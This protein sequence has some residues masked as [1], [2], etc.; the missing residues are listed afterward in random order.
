MTDVLIEH[1]KTERNHCLAEARGL[2]QKTGKTASDTTRLEGALM[3]AERAEERIARFGSSLSVGREELTYRRDGEHSYFADMALSLMN[4]PVNQ[5][6]PR[7]KRLERH[8]REMQVEMARIDEKRSATWA[9]GVAREGWRAE[10]RAVS[11][12]QGSAGSFTPPLYLLEEFASVPRSGRTLSGKVRSIPMPH[13]AVNNIKIP[14]FTGAGGVAVA[15]GEN[16]GLNDASLGTTTDSLTLPISN[17]AGSMVVAQQ[18]LDQAGPG[19]DV[20]AFSDMQEDFNAKLEAAVTV[21]TGINGQVK[22]ILNATGIGATPFTSATPTPAGALAALGQAFSQAAT[23]RKRPPTAWFMAGRRWAWLAS[24]TGT[25]GAPFLQ[26]GGGNFVDP[27]VMEAED[28]PFGPLVGLPT[29]L[30]SALP[31]NQ[32]ASTNQDAAFCTRPSDH[33]LFESPVHTIAS[34]GEYADSMG[35]VLRIYGYICFTAERYPTATSVVTGTGM[36]APAGY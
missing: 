16:I 2:A 9:A 26:Q 12:A 25:D 36:T 20:F 27:D 23:A 13:G 6:T 32:G 3:D 19:F 10:Y 17:I 35:V 15:P 11:T 28:G 34:R 29:Y 5:N 18:L 21:G 24:Q 4:G 22:G 33:L 7:A 1:L 31:L 14:R 8:A 30:S